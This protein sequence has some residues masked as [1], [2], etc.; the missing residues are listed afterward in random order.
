MPAEFD[1]FSFE[2]PFSPSVVNNEGGQASAVSVV[3]GLG[4]TAPPFPPV[5]TGTHVS[6]HH[7][8]M[9]GS[10]LLPFSESVVGTGDAFLSGST[11]QEVFTGPVD[12]G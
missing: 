12:E 3:P 9:D 11:P 7:P 2:P 5:E 4:G 10:L 1:G 6:F 8:I